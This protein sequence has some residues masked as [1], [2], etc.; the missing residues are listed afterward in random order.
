MILIF[1]LGRQET[2]PLA[3]SSAGSIVCAAIIS[4]E[5]ME[6]AL[7][8]TKIVAQDCRLRGTAFRVGVFTRLPL[9]RKTQPTTLDLS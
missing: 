5:S 2:T 3:G 9:C 7:K 6:E 1:F 4:G 8:A